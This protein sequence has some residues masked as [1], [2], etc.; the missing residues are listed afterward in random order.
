M[1][2]KSGGRY[3]CGKCKKVSSALESL[4]DD[5]PESGQKPPRPGDLPELGLTIDF[6]RAGQSRLN[7]DEARLTGEPGQ[8]SA[9]KR[10]RPWLRAAW[11]AAALVLA[12]A[13]T[14]KLAE[15]NNVPLAG[16]LNMDAVMIRLGLKDAPPKQAFRDVSQIHLVSREL[17]A[18]PSQPGQLLLNATIVNRA[19]R[20][21]PYPVIEV[22][23][24]NAAGERL[25]VHEFKPLN[26][27]APGSTGRRGMS[28]QAYLPVSLAIEDPGAA[29]TG[30]ELD[31][32]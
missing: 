24:L 8:P 30:F 22:T 6:T 27:L 32:R 2:A 19:T 21:Q 15:F 16:D 18:H 23:L 14:V 9:A 7:P 11:I 28:P 29:A 4:F 20:S 26:Y 12:A 13:V 17:A 31:F 3:R 10:G 5:W 25:A 1:L